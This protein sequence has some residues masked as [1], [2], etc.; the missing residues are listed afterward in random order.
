M[1]VRP[2]IPACCDGYR[3]KR[4][5][6]FT[7][8]IVP[9]TNL[10]GSNDGSSNATGLVFGIPISQCLEN[11]R[12]LRNS[13]GESSF[14]SRSEVEEP[15]ELCRKSHHGSRSS[16]SSLIE[17]SV[18]AD[19][20]GSCESL[21][22]PTERMAGS[23][24]GLLDTLSCGSAAD[25]SGLGE[26]DPGIP[27]LVASCL[28]HI[29]EHGLHTL[30]IFRVSS[31]KKRVRQ[32][33]EDFD[34]GKEISLDD[35]LC[36]HDVATL[37]KE[38]FRDL[39]E[40]LLCRDLYLAFVQTQR[41][42]NRRLQFEALQHLIQLLPAA[43]RDTLWALLNFLYIVARNSTDHTDEKGMRIS[44]QFLSLVFGSVSSTSSY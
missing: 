29:E 35:D 14:R 15:S 24:P 17:T 38:F 28:R 33:R 5:D 3:R 16:F 43:N 6:I 40:P 23:V 30:G 36:P 41:I 12:L 25:I 19:E 22:S 31:S 8:H 11:D 27:H 7:V 34:C 1:L 20:S 37:L 39:P 21:M 9:F 18:R 32:L 2:L 42:R 10:T 26:R 44:F 4:I 13:R